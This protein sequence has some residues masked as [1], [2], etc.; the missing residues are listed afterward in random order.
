M[1]KQKTLGSYAKRT[2]ALVLA[3]LIFIT[4]LI[5]LVSVT[6]VSAAGEKYF[7]YYPTDTN[8]INRIEDRVGNYDADKDGNSMKTTYI[9]AQGG[10]WDKFGGT[11]VKFP[12]YQDYTKEFF[13]N[14]D[15]DDQ[16]GYGLFQYT[17]YNNGETF[18]M[19]NSAPDQSYY[20]INA[21]IA[22]DLDSGAGKFYD[23]SQYGATMLRYG[24]VTLYDAKPA[25]GQPRK[26]QKIEL[27]TSA[28]AA[29]AKC[30]SGANVATG[31]TV[32]NY[33]KNKTQFSGDIASAQSSTG[34]SATGVNDQDCQGGGALGWIL[35]PIFELGANATKEAFDHVLKPMLENVPV[36]Y[37]S[38]DPSFKAWQNFR[39]IGNIVLIGAMLAIV[40][41]QARGGGR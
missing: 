20:V 21:S 29:L 11:A 15:K 18:K 37:E 4:M 10:F 27:S 14:N 19:G 23:E 35:C 6:R 25:D 2:T 30:A 28:D 1:E 41:A 38:T 40:Y 13:N 22:I 3:T 34:D 16:F 8:A 24:E 26:S 39:V 32:L 17:C 5:P 7:F 31:L 12:F 33:H 36:T 9:A